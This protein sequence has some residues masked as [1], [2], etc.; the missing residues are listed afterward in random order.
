[1]SLSSISHDNTSLDQIFSYLDVVS[2]ARVSGACRNFYA[3][4]SQ[5]RFWRVAT[6]QIA[7]LINESPP[8]VE[9]KAYFSSRVVL[10]EKQILDKAKKFLEAQPDSICAHFSVYTLTRGYNWGMVLRQGKL[11]E[12]Y[13][14]HSKNIV[15]YQDMPNFQ[16]KFLQKQLTLHNLY[17]S[18]TFD[19]PYLRSAIKQNFD[20]VVEILGCVSFKYTEDHVDAMIRSHMLR[21]SEKVA[22]PSFLQK[23]IQVKYCALIMGITLMACSI[24]GEKLKSPEERNR[25]SPIDLFFGILGVA[26]LAQGILLFRK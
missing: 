24:A 1:M 22:T 7:K 6:Q 19:N 14:D 16:A 13:P 20:C 4:A 2:L 25:L 9:C 18:Y 10:N 21:W 12:S 11:E 23:A 15:L 8:S 3:L 26:Y 5:D 17:H